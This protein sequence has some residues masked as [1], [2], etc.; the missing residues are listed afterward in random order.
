MFRNIRKIGYTILSRHFWLGI[1]IG[2]F[3]ASVFFASV[4][5]ASVVYSQLDK[6]ASESGT[7]SKRQKIDTS[8][9]D[10]VKEVKVHLNASSTDGIVLRFDDSISST[11][12]ISEPLSIVG[13]GDYIFTFSTACDLT[14]FNNTEQYFRIFDNTSP[15]VNPM[16]FGTYTNDGDSFDAYNGAVL[17]DW[18]FEFENDTFSTST[19]IETMPA[20]SFS[21]GDVAS[22]SCVGTATSSICTHYYYPKTYPL[23]PL[24]LFIFTLIFTL[25]TYSTFWII[26]Q[27]T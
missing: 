13:E 9:T 2:F 11:P 25:S 26:R 22:S 12:C 15:F 16:I 14:L 24:N 10:S 4:V 7:S 18:Y 3:C 27:L 20:F 21:N 19:P 17:S 1:G 6:T 8:L 23:S 5:S